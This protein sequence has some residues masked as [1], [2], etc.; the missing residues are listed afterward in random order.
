MHRIRRQTKLGINLFS[1]LST[2]HRF[3]RLLE[4]AWILGV[5]FRLYLK[6]TLVLNLKNEVCREKMDL[7]ETRLITATKCYGLVTSIPE[8]RQV[9]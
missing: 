7:S 2:P 5:S 3:R 9:S 8:L 1:T 4:P 6:R